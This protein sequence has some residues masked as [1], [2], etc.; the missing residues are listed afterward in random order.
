MLGSALFTTVTSSS[1]MNTAMQTTPS[2]HHLLSC[3]LEVGLSLRWI[4]DMGAVVDRRL[5]A[6]CRRAGV[7]FASGRPWSRHRAH[8]DP[9]GR[10]RGAGS[11]DRPYAGARWAPPPR[12]GGSVSEPEPPGALRR[13]LRD[14]IP[15]FVDTLLS[16][17]STVRGLMKSWAPISGF[18]LPSAARRAI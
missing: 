15:S 5:P 16:C 3:S 9:R 1:N 13:S 17:H 18:V 8:D 2:V 12:P 14:L 11:P 10:R 6:H 4:V 7:R